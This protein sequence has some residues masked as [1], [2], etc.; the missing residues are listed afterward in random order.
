MIDEKKLINYIKTEIN[1][2]GDPFN[3]TAYEF[4][5]KLIDYIEAI[6]AQ[7]QFGGWTPVTERLP[8]EEGRYLCAYGKNLMCVYSFSNDLFSVDDYD[9]AKYKFE[10]KKG[11]YAYDSEWGYWEVDFIKAWQPLP[12]PYK[13]SDEK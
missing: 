2:Y 1:P 8:A 10:K 11:F 7:P 5:L 9:F 3:D 12:E 6:E 13:E 4:G